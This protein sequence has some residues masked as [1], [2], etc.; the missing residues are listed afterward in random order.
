MTAHDIAIST[1]PA[2]DPVPPLAG[3]RFV[4]ILE[5]LSTESDRIK[6]LIDVLDD[7]VVDKASP[8]TMAV[9]H[10]LREF[11][12]RHRTACDVAVSEAMRRERI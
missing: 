12:E 10:C 2:I 11:A 3:K 4:D 7:L 8:Q 6:N 1:A 9:V 5:D